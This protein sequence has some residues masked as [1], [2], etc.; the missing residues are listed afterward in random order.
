[1]NDDSNSISIDP[2][3]QKLVDECEVLKGELATLLADFVYIT[4]DIIPNIEADYMVK[5]GPLQN[6]LLKVQIE[7]RRTKR[8]IELIQSAINR[9]EPIDEYEIQEQ[10]E[11][12]YKSWKTELD[13]QT[14]LVVQSKMRLSSLLSAEDSVLLSKLY[15]TL[16]KKLHPDVNPDQSID[17]QNLWLQVQSAYESGDLEQMKALH[18]L[19]ETVPGSYDLPNSIDILKKRRD[20]FKEQIYILLQKLAEIKKQPLFDWVERLEDPEFVAG[21]QEKLKAEI[22]CENENLLIYQSILIQLKQGAD[23]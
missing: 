8:E 16:A 1:M 5:L 2:E 20:S 23:L 17:A 3:F 15:K 19:A 22:F 9:G 21:E 14:E 12:E 18:I 13:K 11:Q 10:L 4:T 7:I 6:D